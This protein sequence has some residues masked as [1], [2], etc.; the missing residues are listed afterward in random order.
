MVNNQDRGE[1]HYEFIYFSNEP[2]SENPPPGHHRYLPN[3]VH[4]TLFLTLQIQTT[5]HVSTGTVMM[6]SDIGK[7]NINLI[8]TMVQNDKK[9]II[10]GSS[11]K[12]CI[13][14]IYEAITNSRVGVKPKKPEEYPNERLPA[15]SKDKLCPASVAFGASGEKWGWQGL[16]SIQDAYCEITDVE[17]GFIP[18]LW[19]PQPDKNKSYYTKKDTR[20]PKKTV[21]WKFYYNMTNP[22]NKSEGNGIPIQV[23]AVKNDEF[24]TQLR[25]KNL[26]PEEL[27]ALLIALGQDDK[28]P[29]ILKAGAGKPIGFGSMKIYIDEAEIV[30][31]QADLKARYTSLFTPKNQLLTEET[32]DSFLRNK[33]DQAY[34]TN[35]VDTNKLEQLFKILNPDT[36]FEPKENY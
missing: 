16:I 6:G 24:L 18:N 13:R 14:S 31:S 27:G 3:C 15:K 17:V 29:L 22:I 19:S 1:S 7:P 33:I 26:K 12:G 8:K 21:G 9:L 25:F 5:L 10:Q 36:K 2:P 34:D 11:L 35:F 32:L 30:Q 28:Y 4:G 20:E 23:A